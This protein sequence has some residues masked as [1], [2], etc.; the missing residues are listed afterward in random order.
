MKEQKSAKTM[1]SH[2]NKN[3]SWYLDKMYVFHDNDPTLE[4]CPPIVRIS[5]SDWTSHSCNRK[6][7]GEKFIYILAITHVI[8][9]STRWE[10]VWNQSFQ[11][12]FFCIY[13]HYC[14]QWLW[15]ILTE[16]LYIFSVNDKNTWEDVALKWP[17]WLPKQVWFGVCCLLTPGLSKDI[18]CH[19]WP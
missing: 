6:V 16:L 7:P 15:I 10:H 18:Q 2:Q 12:D 19:V 1:S 4:A 3:S 11:S 8:Q 14:F 5:F 17:H 9:H 13:S